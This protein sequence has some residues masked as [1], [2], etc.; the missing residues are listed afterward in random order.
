MKFEDG[1]P[2][3][4]APEVWEDLVRDFL[5]LDCLLSEDERNLLVEELRH[6]G[7]QASAIQVHPSF[8]VDGR[9]IVI[10]EGM[11]A[12]RACWLYHPKTRTLEKMSTESEPDRG[13][14]DP[15]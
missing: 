14:A 9:V 5:E 3:A 12:A 10:C 11:P 15:G 13:S 8:A 6:E 7:V 4:P 2:F 1:F